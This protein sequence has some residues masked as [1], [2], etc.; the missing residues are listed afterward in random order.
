MPL[1][2]LCRFLD[3]FGASREELQSESADASTQSLIV[4]ITSLCGIQPFETHSLY[5]IGKA[6]REMHHAVIAKEQA[7]SPKIRVLQYSPGPMDTGMQTTIRESAAVAKELSQKYGEM[8][9]N[10]R[11]IRSVVVFCHEAADVLSCLCIAVQG[12]LIPPEKSSRLGVKLT[13][14]GAFETGSHVDYYDIAPQE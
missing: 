5:C 8:K 7:P 6:A 13:L 2:L 14:S 4:N 3:E 12:T 11:N 10:V 1:R 9:A